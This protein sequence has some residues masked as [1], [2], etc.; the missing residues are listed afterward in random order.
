MLTNVVWIRNDLRFEDNTALIKA[1]ENASETDK[2]VLLVFHLNP[3]QF[4]ENTFSHDYFFSAL[5]KFY[6][7]ATKQG[8]DIFFLE[9]K[10]K[11]CFKTLI[12]DFPKIDSIYFNSSDRGYALK[13]DEDIRL[14][15]NKHDI[16]ICAFHDKHLHSAQEIL[17]ND[18][19]FYKVYTPYFNKWIKLPKDPI[20]KFSLEKL[21]KVITT[22]FSD[23][24]KKAKKIFKKLLK[25]RTTNFEKNCGLVVAK[26]YLKDFI[27]NN[28]ENYD[29]NRDFPAKDST[30]HLSKF[31]ATGEISIRGIYQEILK[32]PD[33]KGKEIFIKEL[34]WRDFYNM[35]HHVYKNQKNEEIIEKYRTL[36]WEYNDSYLKNWQEGTT[37]FPII[38]AGMRQLKQEGF[39]HNRLRMIVASFLVKDLLLDWRLGEEYFSKM[40]I[41]YDSASNIGG[42]QWAASVG[43]D[44]SPY[45]RVFNPTLQSKKFDKEAQYIRKYI[46]ELKDIPSKYIHEPSKYLEKIKTEC[47][48]D[49]K[50]TYPLPIVDHKEQRLKAIEM[51]K[52]HNEKEEI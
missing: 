41:D 14:F 1:V 6:T 36:K 35:I 40:L 34:A 2:K 45:F 26:K 24:D 4:K 51:F 37:G 23:N 42:W 19:S 3:A 16:K 29:L 5:N 28:L 12:E 27:E 20:Y 52:F 49:L 44:A 50:D 10:T 30:S 25:K 21:K 18:E 17:K 47:N 15:L 38:D 22:D 48:I 33:S 8:L 7:K 39:M 43:T 13:R 32:A 9:G 11:K 46:P 31:L